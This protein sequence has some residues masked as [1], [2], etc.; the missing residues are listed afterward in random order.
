MSMMKSVGPKRHWT[1]IPSKMPSR[2]VKLLAMVQPPSA[3]MFEVDGSVAPW[4]KTVKATRLGPLTTVMLPGR[5][6]QR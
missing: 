5:S 3:L 6:P 2:E 4:A 1:L